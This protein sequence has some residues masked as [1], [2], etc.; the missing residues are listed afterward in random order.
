MKDINNSFNYINNKK[1]SEV[2]LYKLDNID[3]LSQKCTG[4]MACVD[5][6]PKEC[7]Y[8]ITGNDG[9]CYSSIDYTECIYKKLIQTI[10]ICIYIL[11]KII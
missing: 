5:I 3:N 6:C 2:S 9:F 8:K 4:C 10:S 7:I 1:M 11:T